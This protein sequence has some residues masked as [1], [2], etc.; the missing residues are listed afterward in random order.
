[1]GRTVFVRAKQRRDSTLS[2]DIEN[3]DHGFRFASRVDAAP[4]S[5]HLDFYRPN[6]MILDTMPAPRIQRVQIFCIPTEPN[7]TRMLLVTVRNFATNPA[8][9]LV[10]DKF[11]LKVLHQDK[12]IVESSDPVEVPASGERS[13]PT[14]R[15]TLAFRTWY[16]R[17]LKGTSVEAPA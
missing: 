13:V 4:P 16:L 15:P 6:S 1:M 11:N 8:A 2:F 17:E 14:D 7:R 9:G 12:A 3:T 5:A 10:F